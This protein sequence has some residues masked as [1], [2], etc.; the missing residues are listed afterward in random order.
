MASYEKATMKEE[1][2]SIW[3]IGHSTRPLKEFVAMLHSF[4]IELVTDLGNTVEEP[5]NCCG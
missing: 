1:N 4:Q 2:K 3:T 5:N